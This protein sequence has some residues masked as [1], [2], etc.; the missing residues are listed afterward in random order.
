LKI[1]ITDP[2]GTL[3]DS[4]LVSQVRLSFSRTP[5]P[6]PQ[7]RHPKAPSCCSFFLFQDSTVGRA[8][9]RGGRSNLPPPLPQ[10]KNIVLP[11][12][13]TSNRVRQHKGVSWPT[14]FR[15]TSSPRSSPRRFS[16]R[17]TPLEPSP[18]R[19]PSRGLFISF[20]NK[21][22]RASPLRGAPS[23]FCRDAGAV[24]FP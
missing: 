24:S 20:F 18:L 15:S 11:M 2:P 6:S 17:S 12:S 4:R 16:C 5:P 3:F 14:R 22:S 10:E 1:P 21:T 23:T 19:N 9:G 13:V 8:S 7:R